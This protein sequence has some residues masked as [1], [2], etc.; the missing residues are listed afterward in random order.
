MTEYEKLSPE[1]IFRQIRKINADAAQRIERL[2][3]LFADDVAGLGL[4]RSYLQRDEPDFLRNMKRLS[5]T[6]NNRIDEL[7]DN[8]Y[9]V[10]SGAY[11]RTWTTGEA[12]GR[13]IIKTKLTNREALFEWL[14]KEGTFAHRAKAMNNFR[15]T[16]TSFRLSSRIWK[17]GIRGQ[18][19]DAL[20]LALSEGKSADQLS[21][22]LRRYLKEPDRL[23]RRVRDKETG[24]L[25]LSQ[26]AKDYHP[27]QGVYR[28]SYQNALRLAAN[29]INTAYRRSEREMYQN[30]PV[31]IGYRISLSN[32]HTCNGLPFVDI[33]DYAEGVYPKDF[34]WTGWHVKCRCN[35][36]P[37]FASQNDL[38]AMQRAILQGK[39]PNVIRT[40]QI[41]DIPTSFKNWSAGHKEQ[42]SRWKSKP[43]YVLDNPNYSKYFV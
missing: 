27:G 2:F 19:E 25:K 24:E 22:D 30:N 6:L 21:L 32:N 37:V 38:A 20:Q 28:S 23:Y 10:I 11:T 31:I 43:Y 35:M 26:N 15:L 41:K 4:I 42:L 40:R 12:L 9:L 29:E 39:D 18:I 36:T 16:K 34:V 3:L 33:C 13:S 14:E 7:L 1:E 5:G 17:E 8:I